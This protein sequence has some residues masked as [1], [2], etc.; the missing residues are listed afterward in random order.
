MNLYSSPA[1]CRPSVASRRS[2]E[3]QACFPCV[4][5]ESASPPTEDSSLRSSGPDEASPPCSRSHLSPPHRSSEIS[6]AK[7][8]WKSK[9]DPDDVIVVELWDVVDKA[10]KKPVEIDGQL[11]LAHRSKGVGKDGQPIREADG[12]VWCSSFFA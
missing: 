8:A 11:S 1:L 7:I 3:I 6:T 2:P 4:P 9:T 12:K 5:A 10:R